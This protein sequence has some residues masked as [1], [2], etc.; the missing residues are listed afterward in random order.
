MRL[1]KIQYSKIVTT[2]LYS[3]TDEDTEAAGLGYILPAHEYFHQSMVVADCENELFRDCSRGLEGG[4]FFV[5]TL[6]NRKDAKLK[7]G[8]DA[9]DSL[10]DFISLKADARFCHYFL[11]KYN[12]NPNVDNTPDLLKSASPEKKEAFVHEKVEETLRELLPYFRSCGNSNPDLVDHPLQGGRRDKSQPAQESMFTTS[13]EPPMMIG[14][15]IARMTAQKVHDGPDATAAVAANLEEIS[16][17]VSGTRARKIFRCKICNFQSRFR[18]V[19]ASHIETCFPS[20]LCDPEPVLSSTDG[21]FSTIGSP[22]STAFP[23]TNEYDID[24]NENDRDAETDD[25]FWNYKSC[26]FFLDSIFCIT[27]NYEKFGDGL[28]CYIVNKIILPIVHGLKHSNYSNSIHRFITR[29]LCEATPKEGLKLIHEKFSNRAGKPGHNIHRDRR[30]EFRIGTAKNL[31]GNLGPNFSQESVQQVKCTMDIKEEL[32]KV[33][34]LSHGVGIR[35]GRHNPRSD[36]RDYEI[37][38]THLT[39]TRAHQRVKGR[40]FGNL[41]F[42]EGLM[43]DE[44][45]NKVEFYRWIVSKNKE[46]ASV[47]NAKRK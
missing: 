16:V 8:K 10:K 26:E 38:F 13:M 15:N 40:K 18:T 37:L 11:K 23:E 5:A 27:S 43:D 25:L 24:T 2:S 21:T 28:G 31:I 41:T 32:H 45:F 46:A 34:R 14:D 19:C 17:S 22:P 39:E 12:L 6:L 7:R 3:K 4:S 9:I 36:M 47:L 42:K 29:V 1:T 33:T 30:M 20:E 44:K 35:S